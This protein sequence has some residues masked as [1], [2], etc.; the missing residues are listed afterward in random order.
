MSKRAEAARDILLERGTVTTAE[1]NGLGYDHPPRAIGD[2]KDAGVTVSTRMISVDG[3][4]MA[5]Y[6]LVDT[7]GSTERNRKQLPKK[8]REALYQQHVYRCAICGG[9]YTGRELQVDHRI[10]FRISGDP[11]VLT[12]DS[13]MPLCG[14]DNRAKS[15]TCE[16]C[17]NW[18]ARDPDMCRT[19]YWANPDEYAHIA[20]EEERR[21]IMAIQ[22][23]EVAI[24]D[25]IKEAAEADDQSPG[26]WV[27]RRLSRLIDE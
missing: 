26:D 11:D 23:T 16:H 24:F 12:L 20:G 6:S 1:L 18:L 27:Q 19:F 17:P 2:L 25:R 8:F 15:W 4:R 3:R 5:Q 21:L 22:G 7:V 9:R 10:P 13:F 14:S